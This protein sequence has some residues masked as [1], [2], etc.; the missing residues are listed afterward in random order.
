MPGD[1]NLDGRVDINDLTVVLANYNQTGM[2]WSNGE[3]TGSGTVDINDLT[4]VLA[5]YNQTFGAASDIKAVP[6]PT[7]LALLGIAAVSLFAF[8][9]R[10]RR[11]S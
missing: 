3:F 10:K 9:W 6:E 2:V 4:I 8:T 1:A 7:C 5:N 11:A